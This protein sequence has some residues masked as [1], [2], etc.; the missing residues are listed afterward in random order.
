MDLCR[1]N[2]MV[3]GNACNSVVFEPMIM[4][5]PLF[6]Q[7]RMWEL[8]DKLNA[9]RARQAGQKLLKLGKVRVCWGSGT[10]EDIWR[11]SETPNGSLV[12]IPEL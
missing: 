7:K 5:I 4:S 8:E 10:L 12:A 1:N 2:A 11:E 3:S 9:V 6:H